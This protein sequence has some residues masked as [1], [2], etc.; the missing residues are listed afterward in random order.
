[1]RIYIKSLYTPN[2]L[3]GRTSGLKVLQSL[4]TTGIIICNHRKNTI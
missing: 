3:T 2:S 1:M 4:D